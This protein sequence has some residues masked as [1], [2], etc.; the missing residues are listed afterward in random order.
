MPAS[1]GYVK[2]AIWGLVAG[3][4][5][6]VVTMMITAVMGMGLWAMPMMIA[7]ILL[8]PSAMMGAGAGVILLGLMMHMVLSM[9]FG[10]AYGVVVNLCTH[11]FLATA[12]VM[13]LFLWLMN[14]YA[15]DLIVPGAR[16]MA[17]IEPIWLAIVSHLVFGITLGT[18]SRS[19]SVAPGTAVRT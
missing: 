16:T 2:A 8:G 6:A 17:Q 15:L 5:M 13:S 19:V 11:E 12:I 1:I 7:A 9:M 14:F 10:I 4:V 18:L 3:I